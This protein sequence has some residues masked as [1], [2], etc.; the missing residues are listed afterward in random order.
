MFEVLFEE[1]IGLEFDEVKEKISQLKGL[2]REY[3]F[4]FEEGICIGV[5]VIDSYEE[6]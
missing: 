1:F 6:D 2:D 5:E 3:G 4:L